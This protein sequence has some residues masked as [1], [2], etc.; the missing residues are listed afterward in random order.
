MSVPTPAGMMDLAQVPP[1]SGVL[2]T[3]PLD[4]G[5]GVAPCGMDEGRTWFATMI[6]PTATHDCTEGQEIAGGVSILVGSETLAQWPPP[7][8]VVAATPYML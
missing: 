6:P 4:T 2:T 8:D 5:L 3:L 1:P 7:S